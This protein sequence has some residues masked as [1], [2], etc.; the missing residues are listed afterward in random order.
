MCKI[1]FK[2]RKPVKSV[3]PGQTRIKSGQPVKNVKLGPISR[4]H[5]KFKTCVCADSA[6][7]FPSPYPTRDWH[8][9]DSTLRP[10]PFS[11]FPSRFTI[12]TS[13]PPF[14]NAQ[15]QEPSQPRTG[16]LRSLSLT[17]SKKQENPPKM[18]GL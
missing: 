12:S 17:L 1:G 11:P 14:L 7:P 2:T 18:R 3:K 4:F 8:S 5:V 15:K 13:L 6:P 16:P 10:F 9:S